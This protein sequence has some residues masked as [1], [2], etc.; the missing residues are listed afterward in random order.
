MRN[1]SKITIK[2][3]IIVPYII[4]FVRCS[5]KIDLTTYYKIK[6]DG[7]YGYIDST[8]KI[9]IQPQ[10]FKTDYF[11]E[12]LA[13]VVVD[14]IFVTPKKKLFNLFGD[15][16]S[17]YRPFSKIYK[18]GYIN[19]KNEFVIKPKLIYKL[20][21]DER[22]LIFTHFK[23]GLVI[24]QN[25]KNLL[26]GYMNHDGDTVI[27]AKFVTAEP[28]SDSLAL[29][30]IENKSSII[31]GFIDHTGKFKIGPKY[32]KASDF[33]EGLSIGHFGWIDSSTHVAR[34]ECVIINK[35][36]NNVGK[37][38]GMTNIS[39]FY[40]GF[41]L[42]N[43]F[44]GTVRFINKKGEFVTDH[45]EAAYPFSDGLAPVKV[46]GKWGFIN[47]EFKLTIPAIY[48]NLG[49][50]SNE[51]F[52]VKKGYYWGYINNAGATVIPFKFDTC[53]SFKNNLATFVIK[54]SGYKINGYINKKGDIVWQ[55]ETISEKK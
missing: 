24:Y 1:L 32:D 20:P 9:I 36:G 34:S 35:N 8:G 31:Y 25:D 17:Y 40:D 51:L 11:S 53:G 41:A 23:E 30:G 44:F 33:N 26:Y 50:F 13:M 21:L 49:Y 38:F 45:L 18:Y 6:V 55:K 54:Q 3:L 22:K 10:Y 47:N 46:N 29:V 43:N 19:S 16:S 42:E 4:L 37:P 5:E 52:P 27:P 7:K 28:F 39:Q 12:G 14:T 48:D 15:T 2:L